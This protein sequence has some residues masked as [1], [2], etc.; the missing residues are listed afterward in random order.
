MNAILSLLTLCNFCRGDWLDAQSHRMLGEK[1][2]HEGVWLQWPHNNL[3]GPHFQGHVEQGLVDIVNAIQLGEN[4]HITVYYPYLSLKRKKKTLSAIDSTTSAPK[5]TPPV[6]SF[7]PVL[8]EFID[9][10]VFEWWHPYPSLTI[11]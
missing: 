9:L 11:I 1:E 3:Y 2:F 5:N 7:N 10:S 6:N 8:K 4:I